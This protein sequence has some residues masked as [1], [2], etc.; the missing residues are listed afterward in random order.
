M[1]DEHD[2]GPHDGP[3]STG[4]PSLR[5]GVSLSKITDLV[6]W[7]E[8][9][10][11]RGIKDFIPI[12]RDAFVPGLLCGRALE[13]IKTIRRKFADVAFSRPNDHGYAVGL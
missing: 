3:S 9:W 8:G 4:R 12:G 7:R 1:T 11:G 13:F 10:V 2:P 6:W 5:P